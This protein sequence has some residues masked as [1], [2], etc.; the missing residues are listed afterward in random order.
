[1]GRWWKEKGLAPPCLLDVPE[2]DVPGMA[3][4]LVSSSWFQSPEPTSWWPSEALA[5]T[6]PAFF[7][8]IP[9]PAP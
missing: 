6:V 7:S 1:M 8:S 2:S 4:H 9:T 3:Y 5:A